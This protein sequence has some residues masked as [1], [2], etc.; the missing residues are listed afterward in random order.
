MDP[1]KLL[2]VKDIYRYFLKKEFKMSPENA[3]LE[4]DKTNQ[5]VAKKIAQL[6]EIYERPR[7]VGR[8]LLGRNNNPDL[9]ETLETDDYLQTESECRL[10]TENGLELQREIESDEALESHNNSQQKGDDQV[11]SQ[12]EDY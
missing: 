2:A 4:A 6:K 9:E 5:C 11:E 3:E 1:T 10:E 7:K 12:Y 8:K